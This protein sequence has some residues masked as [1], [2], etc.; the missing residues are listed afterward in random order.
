MSGPLATV[1]LGRAL[2][3]DGRPSEAA[4]AFS[5]AL[6]ELDS[7]DAPGVELYVR[8]LLASAQS[9]MGENRGAVDNATAVARILVRDGR[10][11]K[12]VEQLSTAAA[13]AADL[14][15]PAPPDRRPPR[16]RHGGRQA[17]P[18]PLPARCRPRCRRR[19]QPG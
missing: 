5:T 7:V 2:A 10:V 17:P 12:A 6:S 13:A 14:G 16:H 18:L 19:A 3:Q 15:R 9:D 8:G 11:D 4:E 1:S